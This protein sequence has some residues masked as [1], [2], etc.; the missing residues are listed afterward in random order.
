VAPRDEVKHPTEVTCEA[1]RLGG[2]QSQSSDAEVVPS[3]WSSVGPIDRVTTVA[4]TRRDPQTIM[5]RATRAARPSGKG[6]REHHHM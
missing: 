1:M 6:H 3:M 2:H 4:L 5:G